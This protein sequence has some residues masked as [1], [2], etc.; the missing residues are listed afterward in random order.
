MN[1]RAS[2]RAI[3]MDLLRIAACIMV[4]V[5]HVVADGIYIVDVHSEKWT[6]LTSYNN[7]CRGAVPLFFMLSGMFSRSADWKKALK[8]AS[9]YLLL[10]VIWTAI[11]CVAEVY[12]SH[13][14][15]YWDNAPLIEAFFRGML[16]PNYHLWFIPAFIGV[17]V[18]SP[19]VN[20]LAERYP[21]MIDYLTAIFAVGTLG[22][23]TIKTIFYRQPDI[24]AWLE[25]LPDFSMG[26]VG[27][28]VLGRWM[29]H[30]K[31]WLCKRQGWIYLLGL[32]SLVAVFM[33]TRSASFAVN[34]TNNLFY[35]HFSL[36]VTL[37]AVAW[38]T[39]FWQ[40]RIPT[41][42]H[43]VIKWT[44]AN[45]LFIY[46]VHVMVIDVMLWNG[47]YAHKIHWL[48]GV[49]IKTAAVFVI[50]CALC[51]LKEGLKKAWRMHAAGRNP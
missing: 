39:L 7:L 33:G 24:L 43:G 50:C 18:F 29:H 40:F 48:L 45:T 4:I 34:E 23:E 47:I 37:Q 3:Q 32:G 28:Y 9:M 14:V 10:Y 38:I 20:G 31:A 11:Y 25:M 13:C 17:I 1:Q 6:V 16:D 8:K 51:M 2:E 26:Y 35:D 46:L 41:C 21:Q 49:P 12:E 15:L 36:F 22:V 5:I 42:L 27:L 19:A 30:H 44:A